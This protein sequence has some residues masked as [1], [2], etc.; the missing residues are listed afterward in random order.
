[1]KTTPWPLADEVHLYG[2]TLPDCPSELVR[3]GSF[4]APGESERAGLLKSAL[5]ARRYLAGRGL[6]REILGGY[7]GV[8]PKHVQLS[9]GAHGK[10]FLL[11]NKEHLF[12]NLAHS[13]DRFLLA[14]T[15][16]REVGIDIETVD[17]DKPLR[18]MSRLVFSRWEQQQLAALSSPGLEEAFCRFWVRKE[19]CLKA[20]G[21]GFSLA[22]SGFDL[23][24]LH[25]STTVMV[26]SCNQKYWHVLD[27]DVPQRYCAA[28]AVEACAPPQ[29]PPL[30]VRV[31][32]R[33]SFDK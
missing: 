22:G 10:P 27:V 26:A 33:L 1:M 4:L 23:S 30:P 24:P 28:L 31:E 25:E 2:L 11:D 7:L 12:F 9:A 19:A 18:E 32:H 20:C 21:R 14:V 3:L 29:P 17:R 5:A 15:V 8:E 16:N 13:D 6:L